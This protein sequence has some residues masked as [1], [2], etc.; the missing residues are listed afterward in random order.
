[1]GMK[2]QSTIVLIAFSILAVAFNFQTVS[3]NNTNGWYGEA[4]VRVVLPLEKPGTA[5]VEDAR[6]SCP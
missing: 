5:G 6:V 2:T 4:P 3:D 1:M